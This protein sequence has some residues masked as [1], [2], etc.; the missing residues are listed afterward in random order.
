MNNLRV[1]LITIDTHKNSLKACLYQLFLRVKFPL[2]F[3]FYYIV[4]PENLV[5]A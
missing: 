5:T 4:T 3:L 2:T 1:P